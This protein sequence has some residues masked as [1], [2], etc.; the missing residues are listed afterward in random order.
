MDYRE[1]FYK[2]YVTKNTSLL[3][4]KISIDDIKRQFPVWKKYFFDILPVDKN[5][6]IA[7]LGCGNGGFIYWLRENG[8]K[9][10]L[11]VDVSIEQIE[12]AKSFGINDVIHSDLINFLK[13]KENLYDIIFLR[14]VLEHFRKDEILN[15]IDL[16]YK[17][18]KKNGKIIIQTPNSTSLFGS[19]YRYLDFTHEI[20]FTENSLRQILLMGNFIDMKFFE[21]APVIH[22]F[23]S[24]IRVVLWKIMK[25][26]LR[27]FLLIEIGSYDKVLTQNIIVIATK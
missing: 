2:N 16:L 25:F 11:G 7:E 27:I 5:A 1:K 21:T 3:Y 18:L 8:Y 9:N 12:C 15:V 22:G 17:S 10:V 20:S 24:F 6:S 4:G 26:F 23:K 13:N 14:D 19:R